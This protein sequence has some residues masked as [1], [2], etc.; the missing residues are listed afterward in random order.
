MMGSLLEKFAGK[1]D[2]IYIDPPF[3]TGSDFSFDAFVGEDGQ[4]LAKAASSIEEKAYRDTWGA[5]IDSYALMIAERLKLIRDLLAFNGSLFL[6]CDWHVGFILR[7]IA[8]EVF[9]S[10][11]FTNKIIWYYDN[12]FQGNVNRFA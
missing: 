2:L 4:K 3:A 5:G 10:E 11:N 8:N 1:I 9:G 12:K 6:H 7:S